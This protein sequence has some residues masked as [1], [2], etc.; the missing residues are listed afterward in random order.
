MTDLA[1]MSGWWTG[2][3]DD[4]RERFAISVFRIWLFIRP[5][6][7]SASSVRMAVIYS[8]L[9]F[10]TAAAAIPIALIAWPG[11]IVAGVAMFAGLEYAM[12]GYFKRLSMRV[13]TA[14]DTKIHARDFINPP[15][16]PDDGYRL[17]CPT[18]ASRAQLYPYTDLSDHSL[19]IQ[20]E[21]DLT[22]DQ[23][24]S[25]YERWYAL[26]P[27]AFMHLE[28]NDGK[29]WRPIAVSIILPLSKA[30]YR[31]ITAKDA[32]RLSVVDLDHEGILPRPGDKGRF[33]LIDTWIVD[34]EGGYGGAGHGKSDNRG[35]N[36]NLLVLHHLTRF[37]GSSAR[38]GTMTFLV[39]TANPHLIPALEMLSF[40][41]SGTSNIGEDFY[42]TYL[43]R[44][45]SVVPTEFTRLKTVLRQVGSCPV[46]AGTAPVPANWYYK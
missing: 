31:A 12:D 35:G 43:G 13:A 6:V 3:A 10:L 30:D 41:K 4:W 29:Q 46:H 7:R 22:R 27:D 42:E 19:F 11:A 28:L 24:E 17:A 8:I 2:Q 15:L 18:D 5:I 37:W 32:H 1:G 38:P 9:G 34:R 45:D 25:L 16:V 33:L 36:A 14:H 20:A 26:C 40:K 39:E 44:M 23:R 21:N